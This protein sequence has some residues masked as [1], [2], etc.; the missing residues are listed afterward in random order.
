MQVRE[1]YLIFRLDKNDQKIRGIWFHNGKEREEVK[2]V[3]DRVVR[4]LSDTQTVKEKNDDFS[5]QAAKTT[6]KADAAASLL[7]TL[8]LGDKSNDATIQASSSNSEIDHKNMVLDKKSLQLSL[9]SLIQDDRF[10]DLLHAQYLKVARARENK[11]S[12]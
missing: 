9:M 1:P 2:A 3:L 5:K 12:D 6:S 11:S 10:L 7:S 4:S 8:T